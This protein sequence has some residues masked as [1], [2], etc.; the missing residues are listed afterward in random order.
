MVYWILLVPWFVPD[1]N[2]ETEAII[3]DYF[4]HGLSYRE[5]LEFLGIFYAVTLSLGQL[6]RILRKPSLFRRYRKSN[7]TEVIQ[8]ILQ[9]L[10][11]SSE[12]FGYSLMHQ[13]PRADGF[14]VD[15]ETVRI[16]LESSRW[17]WSRTTIISSSC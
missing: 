7:L 4:L 11:G 6:P 2:R 1:V 5:I 10:S 12:L 9:N 3:K 16:F 17:S 14:I 13:K 8:A 15:C